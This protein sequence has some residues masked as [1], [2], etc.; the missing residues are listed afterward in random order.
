MATDIVKDHLGHPCKLTEA[1]ELF[2]D[3]IADTRAIWGATPQELPRQIGISI[4]GL[5]ERLVTASAALRVVQSLLP[6]NTDS[7]EAEAVLQMAA[8][9]ARETQDFYAELACLVLVKLEADTANHAQG[10]AL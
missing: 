7:D 3:S 10:A 4:V 9:Y 6:N 5:S 8:A 1:R 2:G